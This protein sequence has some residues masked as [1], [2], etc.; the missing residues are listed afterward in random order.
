MR[1]RAVRSWLIAAAATAL[2][3]GG[4][5][6]PDNSDVL[7]VAPGPSIG[8]SPGGDNSPT[9][10][11]REDTTDRAQFLKFYLSA[12]A[13]DP[14][15]AV[16][17]VKQFLSP[18]AAE[19]FKAAVDVRVIRLAEEPL[20]N[21]G[22]DQISFKAQQVGVLDA[23][24][25]LTPSGD[26]TVTNYTITVQ[27]SVGGSPG[28]FVTKPPP[29]LLISDEALTQFYRPRT[30]YFWNTEHTSLVPD[31][32]YLPASVPA[33]Q[34]PTEIIRW[35]ANG[36]SPLIR[37]AVDTL[38]QGT[39]VVGNVPA[40]SNDKLQ[41]ALTG[42]AV[43]PEDPAALDRLRRQLMWSLRP[44]LPKVLELTVGHNDPVEYDSNDYLS[45]NAAYRLADEPER[46]V[47]YQGQIRRLA[48]SAYAQEA[49]P[50]LRPE[51]NRNVRSAAF[52]STNTRT[53]AAVVVA[54][55]SGTSLRVA[56]A[57]TGE[58]A[59]LRR[60]TLRGQIGPPVWVVTP[61]QPE[62]TGTGLVVAGNQLYSFTTNGGAARRLTW[63][64]GGGRITAVAVAPD[65][66]RVAAIVDGRLY[67][68]ALVT[69]GDG[70]E[71]GTPQLLRTPMRTHTAVD[72]SSEGWLAI[73]G[74]REQNNRVA[75]M[76]VSI[77]GAQRSERLND[78]GSVTVSYLTA[79]PAAP[80]SAHSDSVVY[81]ASGAA[82]E[83]LVDP[84]PIGPADLA[85][86][87]A[88][89]PAGAAPTAPLFL[90]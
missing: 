55:G 45:S 36:P 6:I 75:I 54:E 1:R 62:G 43:P 71:L 85:D 5:G 56:S 35:L 4:C 25:I 57:R 38:P 64:E 40:A 77:D 33:T 11:N 16:G 8:T 67:L 83:A 88:D 70:W 30:V 26:A 13:G 90:R 41:I 66:H 21:P 17:R 50:L 19:T 63:P 87:V 37:D 48:R 9:R 24:G 53:Y 14:D 79:Y 3:A 68:A 2:L 12:A 82:Y 76:D 78:L 39:T 32:R 22:S 34:Q 59:D 46:F 31:L 18:A 58:L 10:N 52:S 23:N 73:G 27:S 47:V 15:G 42:Q 29:G 61:D 74:I 65:G 89:P 51:A 20:I 49:V 44:N 60:V 84:T 81:V 72:W 7:A 86:P 28:L 69:A 80:D